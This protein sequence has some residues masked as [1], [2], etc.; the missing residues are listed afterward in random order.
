MLNSKALQKQDEYERKV[1]N[2]L[3]VEGKVA[4]GA[5]KDIFGA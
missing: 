3:G 5:D 4:M 2:A 1:W